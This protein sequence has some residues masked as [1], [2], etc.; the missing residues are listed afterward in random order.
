MV[1]WNIYNH[2]L[3]R[4]TVTK[5]FERHGINDNLSCLLVLK[6]LAFMS[7]FIKQLTY[8]RIFIDIFC[9]HIFPQVLYRT[10]DYE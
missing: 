6:K 3:L 5:T 2:F 7:N 4:L 8:L 10:R 1:D 9:V